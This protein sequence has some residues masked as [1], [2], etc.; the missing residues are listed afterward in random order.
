MITLDELLNCANQTKLNEAASQLESLA[1][2]IRDGNLELFLD[3]TFDSHDIGIL[4]NIELHE[5]H[6]ILVGD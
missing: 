3:L 5:V 4:P 6:D 2:A 1:Q